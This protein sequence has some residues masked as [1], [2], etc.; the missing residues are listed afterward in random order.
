MTVACAS[1]VTTVLNNNKDNA[2]MMRTTTGPVRNH[3]AQLCRRC[4]VPTHAQDLGCPVEDKIYSG[5][6]NHPLDD[7]MLRRGMMFAYLTHDADL[8]CT[9][10]S[11]DSNL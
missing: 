5:Q 1:M 9:G 6:G 3:D 10:L 7:E 11:Q 8:A 4:Q 2:Y